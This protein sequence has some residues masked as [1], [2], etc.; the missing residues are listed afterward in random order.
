MIFKNIHVRG[1]ENAIH[2]FWAYWNESKLGIIRYW[3]SLKFSAKNL[4]N[5]SAVSK[6]HIMKKKCFSFIS[7]AM[8]VMFHS[9]WKK[10]K[11]TSNAMIYGW[12]FVF[13]DTI[14]KLKQKEKCW[15]F[16]LLAD[17]RNEHV[18]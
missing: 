15:S 14:K 17:M 12:H 9:V 16:D 1:I 4:E 13:L 5:V 11:M 8:E 7:W 18:G 10:I 2:V 6:I 3:D